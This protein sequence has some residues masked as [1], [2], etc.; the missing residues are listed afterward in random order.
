MLCRAN[1]ID[2]AR[3]LDKMAS[4]DNDPPAE[5]RHK[6]SGFFRIADRSIFFV[7]NRNE[8]PVLALAR[9][10]AEIGKKL[11]VSEIL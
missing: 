1:G 4:P 3:Q 11:S 10:A 2:N 8:L 9:G 7:K 6:A 5:S